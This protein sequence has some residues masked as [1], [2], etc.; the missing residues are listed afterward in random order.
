MWHA[1]AAGGSV[2]GGACATVVLGMG[3]ES[4]PLPVLAVASGTEPAV[5]EGGGPPDDCMLSTSEDVAV[6]SVTPTEA[7]VVVGS[8]V[9]LPR[10]DAVLVT[11][12]R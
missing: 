10:G 4:S 5:V 2:G 12:T 11:L 8:P 6:V 9:A 7:A 1:G 3:P